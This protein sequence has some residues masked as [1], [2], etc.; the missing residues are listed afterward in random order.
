MESLNVSAVLVA[1]IAMHML[2]AIWYSP[3]MFAKAW[4]QA[5]GLTEQQLAQANMAKLMLGTLLL[6]VLMAF[7]LA[8][9]IG[10]T[11]VNWQLGALYG[12]LAGFG[13][14]T[15]ALLLLALYEQRS[16]RYV[17]INGGYLSLGF[18]LMGAII[19]AWQ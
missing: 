3:I 1:A 18:T 8:M 9:F 19:G 10:G 4:M 17:A 15:L 2:G 5:C 14:V 16:W 12:L 11:D 6:C 7:N 13:W